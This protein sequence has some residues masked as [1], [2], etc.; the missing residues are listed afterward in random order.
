MA[1]TSSSPSLRAWR[2][3]FQGSRLLSGLISGMVIGL[4]EVIVGIS[5]ASLIFSGPYEDYLAQGIGIVLIASAALNIVIGVF[6]R[7]PGVI[8]VVQDAPA[9]VLAIMAGHLAPKLV[10]LAPDRQIATLLLGVALSSIITGVFLWLAGHFDLGRLVRYM[11]FPVVAGFLAGIGWLIIVASLGI[12]LNRDLSIDLLPAL[13]E[14]DL[15]LLAGFGL[16]LGVALHIGLRI[17]R[18]V[19]ALPAMLVLA[20]ALFYPVLALLR[21][22]YE[23]AVRIGLAFGSI[24]GIRWQPIDLGQIAAADWLLLLA[25]SPLIPMLFALTLISTLLNL[26]GLETSLDAEF[27]VNRE[28]KTVGL[29]NVA[30]G[31]AGGVAGY[32]TISLTMLNDRIG[33]RSR[34]TSLIVAVLLLLFAVAGASILPY[35]PRPFV[36]GLLLFL[37]VDLLLEW[38]VSIRKQM[39]PFEYGVALV[40]VAV[41]GFVGFLEGIAVGLVLMVILFTVRYSRVDA[42]RHSLTGAQR[43]SAVLR[44]ATHRDVLEMQGHLIRVVEL[45]GYLFF[46]SANRM[47]DT[48]RNSLRGVRYLILD[49]SNVQGLDSSAGG[50]FSKLKRLCQRE[51]II[52]VLSSVPTNL[53]DSLAAAGL[54]DEDGRSLIYHPTLDASLRWCEDRLLTGLS[55]IVPRLGGLA[56]RLNSEQVTRLKDYLDE[57]KLEINE[58]LI[59]AGAAPDDLYLVDRGRLVV[60][61][62]NPRGEEIEVSA[63]EAGTVVG[64]V[65]YFLRQP[66]TATVRASRESLVYRLSAEKMARLKEDDPAL[67]LALSEALSVLLAHRLDGAIRTIN[68]LR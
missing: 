25:E 8:S 18:N 14:R 22:D 23:E 64:E 40:I 4:T 58:V 39:S 9:L 42:I 10:G 50:V 19:L 33:G 63:M 45:Q 6:S 17:F 35:L 11:P 60:V 62:H 24:G 44:P 13:L 29:A 38:G 68:A 49:F 32:P 36:G 46:G 5:F 51:E 31:L 56:G 30:A 20:L 47:L 3:E 61:I 65:G 34:L 1:S 66:R 37:G 53:R 57:R 27:D 55:A 15:L 52:L 67:A 2:E 28:L 21:I 41:I 12:M 26:Q 7:V 59:T 16:A 43:S 54:G 48:L